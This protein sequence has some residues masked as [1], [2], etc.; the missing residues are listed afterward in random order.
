M[1]DYSVHPSPRHAARPH[2]DQRGPTYDQAEV[3]HRI[4]A[5]LATG[6]ALEPGLRVL[7]I[8]T[9][10]GLLA[11]EAASKV[12]P[13]GS[14][15]GVDTSEGMLAE[16]SR[17]AEGSRLQNIDFAIGDA[18]RLDLPPGSFDRLLCASALGACPRFR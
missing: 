8:A 9:G 5:I 11:F 2:F 12:G 14:V 15:L 10:T 7:D 18:E 3:H 16:A 6:A 4:V 17:K 1:T 13:V